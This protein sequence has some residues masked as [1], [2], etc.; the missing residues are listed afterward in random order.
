MENRN[1]E[2]LM[3]DAIGQ[4]RGLRQEL[5]LC[6]QSLNQ[7]I[8]IIG[9]ACRFP[10]DCYVYDHSFWEFLKSGKNAVMEVPKERWDIQKYYNSDQLASGYTYSPYGSF[11]SK[12]TDF[13]AAF[14]GIS[15]REA[16]YIDP[17]HRFMLECAWEALEDS[18]IPP[19]QLR[20]SKTGI[21][22]AQSSDDYHQLINTLERREKFDYYSGTGTSRS[23]LAGRLAYILGTHGPTLQLD[24]SCSSSLT[25]LHLAI[26]S[27][28]TGECHMALVGGVQMNLSPMGGILRSRTQA[29]SPNGQC[30]AFSQ[31]ANGFVQ[32]EGVGVIVLTTLNNAESQHKK[33]RAI[34]RGSAINHDGASAGLT[35]PNEA[36]QID[37]LKGA[38]DNS[39]V[40]PQEVS[41]IETHGTGTVLGDPIEINALNAVYG[42]NRKDPIW[43]G[44]VK[45]NIGHLE[46]AAGVASL[47]KAVLAL[48]NKV[49]PPHLHYETPNEHIDWVNI[50][51]KIPSEPMDW[52]I[53]NHEPCAGVSSFGMS[54][55]NV[56]VIL[57]S[58]TKPS[59]E[60]SSEFGRPCIFTISAKSKNSLQALAKRYLILLH[61]QEFSL[62]RICYTATICRDHFKYRS[63]MIVSNFCQ[64]REFLEKIAEGNAAFFLESLSIPESSEVI[65][66]ENLKKNEDNYLKNLFKIF[67]SLKDL[68]EFR[69]EDMFSIKD[70]SQ[71]RKQ[72]FESALSDYLDN[73]GLQKSPDFEEIA[74][75]L[76]VLRDPDLLLREISNAYSDGQNINWRVLYE[77]SRLHPI[78]LPPYTFNTKPFWPEDVII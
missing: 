33:I 16:I 35:A 72:A 11:L 34:I 53:Q 56:H 18:N 14:F 59:E 6:K 3:R 39:G 64:L 54:G 57:Q 31:N 49:I 2:N 66:L 27:L 15:P 32:G 9:M 65:S 75:A 30:K 78:T 37:V 42:K 76:K 61:N 73:L 60:L 28:R 19:R 13:D 10:E 1:Y 21:F 58:Y 8:A 38:L 41:Y 51:F 26:Q 45:S 46:A 24:T 48:E 63:S 40:D 20:G 29:L 67:P 55:T 12:V 36:A 70:E 50:P 25:A 17:Q 68:F 23:M 77:K 43:V 74:F 52:P 71:R 7:P 47:I 4:I 62:E 69:Y 22:M 5:K 44:S